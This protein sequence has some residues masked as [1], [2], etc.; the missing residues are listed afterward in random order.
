MRLRN[1]IKILCSLLTSSCNV[2]E[3]D[4]TD[5]LIYSYQIINRNSFFKNNFLRQKEGGKTREKT[6]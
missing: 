6:D 1:V 3:K 2:N 5:I 4:G